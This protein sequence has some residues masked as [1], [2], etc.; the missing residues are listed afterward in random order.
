MG[1]VPTYILCLT[2]LKKKP[3]GQVFDPR[4][5]SPQNEVKTR[6]RARYARPAAGQ[7]VETC[8]NV[9]GVPTDGRAA[10]PSP[11]EGDRAAARS[12]AQAHERRPWRAGLTARATVL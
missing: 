2:S 11:L 3:C 10:K 5:G 4:L 9:P 7:W 12:H 6:S 8:R 1:V